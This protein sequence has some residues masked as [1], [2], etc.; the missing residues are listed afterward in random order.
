MEWN[1]KLNL[2]R[3][4]P[5]INT[6]QRTVLLRNW[7]RPNLCILFAIF[8]IEEDSRKVFTVLNPCP[9]ANGVI[10]SNSLLGKTSKNGRVIHVF[11]ATWILMPKVFR[12][13]F[14]PAFDKDLCFDCVSLRERSER[15]NLP[16]KPFILC[17]FPLTRFPQRSRFRTVDVFPINKGNPDPFYV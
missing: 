5:G 7:A 13:T 6:F 10:L 17:P 11:A 2:S 15:R 14:P 12:G 9:L 4:I 16:F 8:R 3:L 1:T